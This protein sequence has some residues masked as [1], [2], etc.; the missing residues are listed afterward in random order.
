MLVGV[1]PSM[2]DAMLDASDDHWWFRGRRRIIEGVL[3]GLTLPDEVTSLDAG[4]GAGATLDEFVR[5]G[6]AYGV[7][8]SPDSVEAARARGHEHV[9]QGS[10]RCASV[11]RRELRHLH[12][13]RYRR[14]DLRR[15]AGAANWRPISE[16]SFNH[17]GRIYDDV[18]GRP[19]YIVRGL[20]NGAADERS[21]RTLERA[22]RLGSDLDNLDGA[23][24]DIGSFKPRVP[25]R[26][27]GRLFPHGDAGE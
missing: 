5:S 16:T 14:A 8:L 23:P 21:H 19:L 10:D 12:Y 1:K 9:E 3:R 4:C 6:A 24:A 2:L 13:R 26:A 7:D 17:I 22:Q 27:P 11:P 25:A 15:A 20:L 18:R